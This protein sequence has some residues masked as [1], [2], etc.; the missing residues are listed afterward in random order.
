MAHNLKEIFEYFEADGT[1]LKGEAYGSGHI[2][3]TFRVLTAERTIIYFK[4]LITRSLKTS[5]NF[6]I[7]LR[8]SRFT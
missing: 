4:G 2:H 8:E 3:D 5:R 1:F 6:S 7:T